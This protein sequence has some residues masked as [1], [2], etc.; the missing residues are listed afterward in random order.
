[1][2]KIGDLLVKAYDESMTV[3]EQLMTTI[4]EEDINP[5]IENDI[6]RIANT[7]TNDIESAIETASKQQP[8]NE[9][10]IGVTALILSLPS[11]IKSIDKV[12]KIFQKVKSKL[13]LMLRKNS[14]KTNTD[15]IQEQWDYI[16]SVADKADAYI[17]KPLDLFLKKMIT[18]DTKR[19]KIVKVFKFIFIFSLGI[20]GSVDFNKIPRLAKDISLLGG[21]ATVE[22]LQEAV[23][24]GGPSLIKF[25]KEYIN[26]L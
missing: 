24:H 17:E 11:I 7:F 5:E 16:V 4:N 23:Q 22:G 25:I 6:V 26:R 10:V 9:S 19:L 13:E 18:D 21:S 15:K 8:V 20:L 14:D 1:M 3:D 12:V 2:E